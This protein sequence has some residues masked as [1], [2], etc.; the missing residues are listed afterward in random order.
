MQNLFLVQLQARDLTKTDLF[1]G[2]FSMIFHTFQLWYSQACNFIKK[3]TL[4][5]VFSSEFCKISE[6]TF[7][8]R[9]PPVAASVRTPRPI[10]QN[11]SEWQLQEMKAHNCV[12]LKPKPPTQV[13]TFIQ[14]NLS[15]T[16]SFA[17]LNPANITCSKNE[18]D[19]RT[20]MM[21]YSWCP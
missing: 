5:Q 14:T 3:G 20:T 16:A 19:N 7:S 2:Y 4:A 21:S 1:Y 12:R 17:S 9:T 6:K 15:K 13:C 11:R 8:Y 18:K 10:F